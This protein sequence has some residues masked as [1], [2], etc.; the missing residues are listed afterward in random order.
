MHYGNQGAQFQ[1]IFWDVFL[2]SFQ[3]AWDVGP[4]VIL[5]NT[6]D[7]FHQERQGSSVVLPGRY[8]PASPHRHSLHNPVVSGSS[9]FLIFVE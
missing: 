2:V 5:R 3:D 8:I 7:K 9:A 1:A 6:W 4:Y